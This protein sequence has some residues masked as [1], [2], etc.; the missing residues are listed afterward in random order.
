MDQ[1]DRFVLVDVLSPATYSQERLP[2]AV[3]LPWGKVAELAAHVLPNKHD[4]VIVSC[5]KPDSDASEQVARE[6]A[7]LGYERVVDYSGG[8]SDWVEGGYPLERPA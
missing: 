8:K 2:G 7:T 3:N 1:G 4:E 5:S 6:L